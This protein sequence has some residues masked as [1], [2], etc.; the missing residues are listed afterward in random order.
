LGFVGLLALGYGASS[1]MTSCP[2]EA[3]VCTCSL[4]VYAAG[5]VSTAISI[6][7]SAIVV[8]A[9]TAAGSLVTAYLALAMAA[10][11]EHVIGKFNT[12]VQHFIGVIDGLWRQLEVAMMQQTRQLNTM[13]VDQTR[14]WGSFA[15][16]ADINRAHK[17][18][19]MGEAASHREY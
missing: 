11:V 2:A 19:S 14:T 16:A 5:G 13:D 6:I 12:L 7:S 4:C 17:Q 18:K 15:D 8:P 1:V 3:Q 9:I 10:F